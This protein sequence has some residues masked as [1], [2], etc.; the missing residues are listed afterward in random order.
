M[1]S[2]GICS[3]VLSL[4]HEIERVLPKEFQLTCHEST[5]TVG[6]RGR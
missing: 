6:P 4:K 5:A 1:L 2:V 3:K